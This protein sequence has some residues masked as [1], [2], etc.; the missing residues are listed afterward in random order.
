MNKYYDNTYIVLEMLFVS[1]KFTILGPGEAR[2]MT[3]KFSIHKIK[4]GT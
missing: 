3:D 2:I 4:V 1:Q